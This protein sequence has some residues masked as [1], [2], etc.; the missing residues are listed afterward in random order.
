MIEEFL[1]QFDINLTARFTGFVVNYVLHLMI[2]FC[3]C[4]LMLFIPAAT[5]YYITLI[6]KKI[7]GERND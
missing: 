6:V 1:S 4:L 5:V 2:I 7:K 3:T